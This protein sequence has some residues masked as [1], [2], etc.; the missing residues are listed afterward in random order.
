MKKNINLFLCCFVA[1]FCFTTG[2]SMAVTVHGEGAYTD[3]DVQ[4]CIYADI[5]ISEALR[6][7]GVRLVY[8]PAELTYDG[9]KTTKNEAVWYL[10]DGGS[11]NEPYKDPEDVEDGSNRAGESPFPVIFS[12]FRMK[13]QPPLPQGLFGFSA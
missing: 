5:D 6:S 10:G 2:Q 8:N 12:F 3:D 13:P 11:N 9:L 1:I 4:V 7:F